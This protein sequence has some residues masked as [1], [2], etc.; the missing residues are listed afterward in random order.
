MSG[1]AALRRHLLPY[2]K[3]GAPLYSAVVGDLLNGRRVIESLV[4]GR[5]DVGPLD[6]YYHDLLKAH[7]PEF[8]SRVRAV[9]TTESAPIPPLVSTA[10][11]GAG[12]LEKFRTALLDG[13]GAPTL[14]LK[15]FSVPR[16]AD[17]TVFDSILAAAA[18]QPGVW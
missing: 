9:A 5:I 8:A 10:K 18:E 4:D 12:E 6:S 16:E 3:G 13:G 11:L 14:L 2:R 15:G 1:W 17:Y 7:E